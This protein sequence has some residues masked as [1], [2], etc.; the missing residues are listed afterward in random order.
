M[1]GTTFIG[2]SFFD[3]VV[4]AADGTHIFAATT[5]G[6]YE[7]TDGGTAW[8]RRRNKLTW[9]VSIHPQAP[10]N[11]VLGREVLAGCQDGLFRS[12]NGGKTWVAVALPGLPSG[13]EPSRLV[14]CHAPSNGSIAYVFAAGPTNVIDPVALLESDEDPP[15]KMPRPRLWRRATFDGAFTTITP[16]QDLQTGQA[17]YD[18]F[19][20]VA[21]N[22]E[23]M[24]YVGGINAHRG[25]RQA[26]GGWTWTNLSAKKP[27]GDCIHPD[28]HVITFSPTNPNVVYIGNDGGLFR[29]SDAGTS[30]E[31]LNKGLS[32]T[33]VEFLA[34]HPEH[35]AWLIAGTQDN[36][37][38]RYEGQ[39]TWYHVQDG[40]GGDCGVDNEDPYICYHSYWGPYIEKSSG[41]G[42]WNGW[43]GISPNALSL[44]ES[45]FYPP[46]EVNGK[47]I[48]RGALQVWLSRDAGAT[49]DAH[50][51][52]D[53][54]YEEYPSAL[55]APTGDLVYVGSTEGAFFEARWVGNAWV[56]TA[57]T[58]PGSGYISDIVVDPTNE[59]AV[60]CS[61][62]SG[63]QG[64]AFFSIDGGGTWASRSN[65]LPPNT[66][67]HAIEIDPMA[68][69]T[70][71]A[72]TDVGVFRTNNAGS[73]WAAFGTGL[74]NVLVKDVLLH[75]KAR[76]LRAGTQAR[77]VWEIAL[78]APTMPDV[79]IYLRDHVAD[80]GRRIP[81]A[82][83]LPNP[84]EKGTNLFWWQSP[85]VKVDASPFEVAGLDELGYD[86]YS[87]YPSKLDQG[88]EF[89]TGLKD[90]RP[91]RGE[92]VRVYVQVHNRGSAIAENIAVKVFVV[93]GGITLPDL[94][95]GFWSG[96]PNN[97]VPADSP[98]QPIA[99]HR[100]VPNVAAGRSAVIGFDWPVPSSLGGT[101]ALL[102]II[103]ADNDEI[104]A[105]GL[106]IKELVRNSRY[107]ALRN[108]AVIN[109]SPLAG[110]ISHVQVFDVWPS[111]GTASLML[112]SK[113]QSLVRGFVMGKALGSGAR[114]AGWKSLR[115]NKTD[116]EYVTQLTDRR[117]ELKKQLDLQNAYFP[118]FKGSELEIS[119]SYDAGPQPIVV[120]LKPNARRGSGSIVMR[121]SGGELCG[122]VTIVNLAG[123]GR[124]RRSA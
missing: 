88:I 124:Q 62:N 42:A 28:Q 85:D 96:F 50:T 86:V 123:G 117:P 73:S 1:P 102:A 78:D 21:P 89:A 104:A 80:T 95:A 115:I 105:T 19:A 13:S 92:T 37:T 18:W 98:W 74:P 69:A 38:I 34:Q 99:A 25:I 30:W 63:G 101:V 108:L 87:D 53:L 109:P 14:A 31:S 54:G 16:P 93:R 36:G 15:A 112:D 11:P 40:D 2:T 106:N 60:W 100:V 120:L 10:S 48:V 59:T 114:K 52:P 56:V 116:S 121:R 97:V 33:E 29:S 75:P 110:P 20:A 77:G 17:W 58:S 39:Q 103:S 3:L 5:N 44:E 8:A 94:P 65:G 23:D 47:L 61:L 49:W 64:G 9:S 122:G 76:L 27:I 82:V 113:A 22:N 90:E 68:P 71:F 32:I 70:L 57:L 24:L 12:K 55:A 91:V 83:D 26:S 46:L 84:F 118:P 107:C 7:T 43:R 4:D 81:S 79:W 41:G 35:D 67:V 45:L 111:E 72:G 119:A 66:A 51:L 6:L